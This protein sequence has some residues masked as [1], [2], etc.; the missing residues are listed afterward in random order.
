MS[1]LCTSYFHALLELPWADTN[2]GQGFE[3]PGKSQVA[4][5]L[6]RNDSTDHPREAIGSTLG[7][8]ASQGKSMCL[9][10]L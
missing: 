4:K 6:F 9:F 8:I 1:S 7:P 5:G 3:P 10:Y 2:G